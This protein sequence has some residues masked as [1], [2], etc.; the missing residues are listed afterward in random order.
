MYGCTLHK[1][2]EN[3][4]IPEDCK[5]LWKWKFLFEK[6]VFSSSVA[7]TFPF[8]PLKIV[9]YASR[10][11][12]QLLMLMYWLQSRRDHFSSLWP[13]KRH[14][15]VAWMCSFIRCAGT[16]TTC[17]LRI[18][19]WSVISLLDIHVRRRN[20]GSNN[21]VWYFNYATCFINAK[22]DTRTDFLTVT[23]TTHF[24]WNVGTQWHYTN[25]KLRGSTTASSRPLF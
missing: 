25:I 3:E 12:P 22:S 21:I 5:V 8:L 7:P 19:E 20:W 15:K 14:G 1:R 24:V 13:N 23:S 18:P 4:T 17:T 16:F 2:M 6:K 10:D 9:I 11:I